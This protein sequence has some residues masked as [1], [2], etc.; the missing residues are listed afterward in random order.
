LDCWVVVADG[1]SRP[2]PHLLLLFRVRLRSVRPSVRALA[3]QAVLDAGGCG[4]GGEGGE[5]ARGVVYGRYGRTFFSFSWGRGRRGLGRGA[6][7]QLPSGEVNGTIEIPSE[8]GDLR[9]LAGVAGKDSV[10]LSTFDGQHALL[11]EGRLEGDGKMSGELLVGGGDSDPFIARRG[12]SVSLPDPLEQVK[13]KE[14]RAL[15]VLR[16]PRFQGK[17][18]IVEIFGTWCPNCNDLAPV[19]AKIHREHRERGLEVLGL[20]YEV[21]EDSDY[22]ERRIREYKSKHGIDWEIAL[23]GTVVR[24]E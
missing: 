6:F 24:P 22:V 3:A 19:L 11:L 20:A 7:E 9:F 15:P 23:A 4:G 5:V 14:G 16:D 21:I 12:E 1:D 2:S 17:A 8:L 13:A 10:F 18:V